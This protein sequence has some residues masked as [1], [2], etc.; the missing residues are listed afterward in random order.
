MPQ[1]KNEQDLFV[2]TLNWIA[3][4]LDAAAIPCMIT[5]GSAVGFWGHIRTTMDIDMVISIREDQV[6]PFAASLAGEA[7]IDADT[8]RD[9]VKTGTMFNVIS[10]KT[11]FKV[12]L[13]PLRKDP[14]E[15]RKFERRIPIEYKQRTVHVISPE[16]LIISKLMW[17]RSMGSSERQIRDCASIFELNRESL[18]IPYIEQW[19]A[20]LRLQNEFRKIDHPPSQ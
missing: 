19:I 12:D 16:D 9:A 13:I 17:S 11:F 2:E 14:Y 3:G 18:D 10:E 4:K 6:A 8:A 1:D 20:A 5:G 7:Y 15:L